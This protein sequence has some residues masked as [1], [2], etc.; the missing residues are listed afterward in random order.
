MNTTLL[1]GLITGIV[2][3]FLLQKGR[4]L[5]FETQ[6]GAMLLQDMTIMK[7]MMSAMLVGMVGIYLM[8][9]AEIIILSHKSMN[10]GA[11]LTGGMLFG[12][13]W[14]IMG[15]C[16][17][18]ALGALG[19][20]RLHAVFAIGGMIAGASLYARA[21]PFLKDTLIAWK[22]FGRIALPDSL[23]VSHWICIACFWIIS[24]FLFLWFEKKGL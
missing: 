2:F 12:A 3:G 4:V 10:V 1:L 23:G 20:G 15:Y 18:T 19:E 24:L 8:V 14:S 11:I 22:D 7:F 6:V 13:G 17:G 5:R 21:Y 9:D 16:P